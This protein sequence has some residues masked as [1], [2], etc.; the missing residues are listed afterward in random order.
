M[1]LKLGNWVRFKVHFDM[2]NDYGGLTLYKIGKHDQSG[3]GYWPIIPI[4]IWHQIFVRE[5]TILTHV[6]LRTIRGNLITRSKKT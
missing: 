2:S 5:I 3:T 4:T 1:A 6:R